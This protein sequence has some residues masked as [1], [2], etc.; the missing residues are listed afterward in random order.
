VVHFLNGLFK[1]GL[2]G[3]HASLRVVARFGLPA[4]AAAFAGAWVLLRL[5]DLPP[6]ATFTLFGH[7]MAIHPAKFIIGL[8]LLV[9]SLLETVPGLA[10]PAFGPSLLPVGGLLSGFFGGL[11]GMQ[12]AL[13][14]AFLIRAGLSKEEFIGT[15]VLIAC[16]VDIARLGVYVPALSGQRAHLDHA[17]LAAAVLAAFAGAAAGNFYLRKITLRALQR[18]VAVMLG[19][20]A[21]GLMTGL[22]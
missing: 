5:A 15:N 11:S 9:F 10:P 19:L 13:R 17:V 1:A 3:R 18:L 22:L 7:P 4:I 20:V 16:L 14:S 12:G 6:L 8:L 2:V 21:I